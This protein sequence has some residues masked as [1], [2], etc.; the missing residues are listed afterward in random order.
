M[1]RTHRSVRVAA[2]LL[3]ELEDLARRRLVPETFTEQV[4]AGL[5]LLIGQA[6]QTETRHAAGLVNADRRRA[7]ETYRL[8]RGRGAP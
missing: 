7:E 2:D 6:L 1:S 5:R 8:L 3:A 4:E